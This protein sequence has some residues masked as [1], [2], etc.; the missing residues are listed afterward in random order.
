[1][2]RS[3]PSYLCKSRTQPKL[4]AFACV[5]HRLLSSSK[6]Q[7]EDFDHLKDLN[8]VQRKAVTFP[9]N[10][11]LQILA[12]PGTGKTRVLTSRII[13]LV[14]NAQIPPSSICAVTFTRRA[15]HEMRSRLAA[16]MSEIDTRLLAVGTF[17][18]VCLRYIREYGFTIGAPSQFAI[19]DEDECMVLVHYIAS[20]Y[21]PN[22]KRS[23][24]TR[25]TQR[26][27]RAKGGPGDNPKADFLE[28]VLPGD[29]EWMGKVYDEYHDV[30]KI[31]DA[32]DFED[33]LRLCLEI[34][35]KAPWIPR[36]TNL[37]HVLV[38]EFQDT[39]ELQY[40][41]LK[42]SFGATAG[43]ATI[44]GDPDQ[45]IYRWRNADIANFKK[46]KK[47]LPNTKE[48]LLEENYRSTRSIL[49]FS[50]AV[51]QQDSK[52]PKKSLFTSRTPNGPKPV[53]KH[54]GDTKDESEFIASE[55]QRLVRSSEDVFGYGDC[56]ILLRE[57]FQSYDL[58]RTLTNKNIPNRILP[59]ESRFDVPE[60]KI[61]LAYLRIARD[62]TY[63]PLI[64]YVL[65]AG[66]HSLDHA[67][68]DIDTGFLKALFWQ[69]IV[70][71][72]PLY[73][74]LTEI[75]ER[76]EEKG[77]EEERLYQFVRT[78]EHLRILMSQ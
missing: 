34:F 10:S 48:L 76:T 33:L 62:P 73:H 21:K 41:F 23:E 22:M 65:E 38:D 56:A 69:S 13:E 4:L 57:N 5:G 66:P 55:I 70:K 51:I 36:L 44:V 16:Q 78:I 6:S 3:T 8:D 61:L 12:G 72:R 75:H 40:R 26:I 64:C 77:W 42:E 15:A 74:V 7:L 28:S 25:I 54:F 45:A 32:F 67:P 27:S 60:A 53:L 46:M 11:S 52:R 2:I 63:T 31:S 43:R 68:D 9:S 39:S 24:A 29:R 30:L 50:L 58:A 20:R 37:Q 18:S 1:M 49:A 71:K 35:K 19:W 47:D 14:R 17:H 59:E